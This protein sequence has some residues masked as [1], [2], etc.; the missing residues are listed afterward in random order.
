MQRAD[1]GTLDDLHGTD[2]VRLQAAIRTLK[3]KMNQGNEIKAPPFGVEILNPFGDDVPEEVQLDFLALVVGY[4]SFV[5]ELSDREKTAAMVALVLRCAERFVA[6]D[7][8]LKLKISRHPAQAVEMALGEVVRQGLIS[9]KNVKGAKYLVSRLLDG[10]DEVRRTTL[11]ALS[12]WPRQTPYAQVI[13]YVKPQL[14]PDELESLTLG[15][16]VSG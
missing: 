10:K 16:N 7:V 4:R 11:R 13:A 9:P 3:E 12:Q 5:P 1:N 2:Q 6:F 15:E 14:E 8:A